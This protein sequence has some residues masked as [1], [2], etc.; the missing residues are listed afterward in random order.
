MGCSHFQDVADP[1]SSTLPVLGR[2]AQTSPG[3]SCGKQEKGPEDSAES[4]RN[5]ELEIEDDSEEGEMGTEGK[6]IPAMGCSPPAD[7]K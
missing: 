2:E 5:E 3:K 4:K 7:L 6:G 1:C